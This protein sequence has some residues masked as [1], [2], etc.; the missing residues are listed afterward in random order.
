MC[1]TIIFTQ[2]RAPMKKITFLLLLFTANSLFPLKVG[3][4]A[5]MPYPWSCSCPHY[6]ELIAQLQQKGHTA[7][8]IYLSSNKYRNCGI[9]HTLNLNE[10]DIEL[11]Y[12]NKNCLDSFDVLITINDNCLR[13]K[14]QKKAIYVMAEPLMIQPQFQS[15]DS[16]NKYRDIFA[17]RHELA[18]NQNIHKGFY[19]SL[20][21]VHPDFTPFKDR[22]LCC[23]I[24]SF[25]NM[26]HWKG[27]LYSQ[28]KIIAQFYD[29]FFPELLTFHGGRGWDG[30]N[31]KIHKGHC[32]D[33]GLIQRNHKFCYCYENSINEEYYISEKI[34]DCFVN[35]CVPIY[36]GCTR[37]TDFIPKETFIDARQFKGVKEIHEF[38]SNMDEE[39]WLGYIKAIEAFVSSEESRFFKKEYF[40][41]SI[42]EVIEK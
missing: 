25:L 41:N 31:I 29:K 28:R 5:L 11:D 34:Q 18:N 9:V 16:Y 40:I 27:E 15:L 10:T 20:S 8:F 14:D 39:T 21:D 32:P 23:L 35:R 30:F 6:N 13:P 37:I 38:I 19:P 7:H 3:V 42:I 22:K 1:H 17:W 24:N 2:K 33:K 36:L 4:V 12:E 26:P